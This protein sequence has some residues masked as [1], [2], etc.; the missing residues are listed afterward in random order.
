M[1]AVRNVTK[2]LIEIQND[3]FYHLS[4]IQQMVTLDQIKTWLSPQEL[5]L[6]YAW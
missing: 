4:L 3:Y 1:D 5:I 6:D 2:G